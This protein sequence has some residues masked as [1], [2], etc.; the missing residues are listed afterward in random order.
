MEQQLRSKELFSCF[1]LWLIIVLGLFGIY[2]ILNIPTQ[3]WT[4]TY[5]SMEGCPSESIK[6]API[7]G[8]TR[9]GTCPKVIKIEIS[10]YETLGDLKWG[11]LRPVAG[12]YFLDKNTGCKVEDSNSSQ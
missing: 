2:K 7:V 10:V 3:Q 12:K 9:D 1:A 4:A 8:F 6:T 5:C 11:I